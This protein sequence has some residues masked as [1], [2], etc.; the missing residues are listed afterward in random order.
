MIEGARQLYAQSRLNAQE[1]EAEEGRSPKSFFEKLAQQ[2]Q[3]AACGFLV[4]LTGG[5]FIY[6]FRRGRVN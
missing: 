4:A 3:S 6:L 5:C 1:E 2:W